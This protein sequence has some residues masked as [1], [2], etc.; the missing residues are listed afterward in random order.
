MS[1]DQRRE[2]ILDAVSRQV[3]DSDMT[4]TTKE[5]AQAAGVAEG[6]LFRVFDSKE[7][8]LIA[9]F[10]HRLEQM[11][12]DDVTN[13]S[14]ESLRELSSLQER[15]DSYIALVA[16]LMASWIH[17][18]AIF[19]R[20]LR[21]PEGQRGRSDLASHREEIKR[22]K[23]IYM[24]TLSHLGQCCRDLIAPYE[25]Q[26]SMPVDTV[27]AFVQSTVTSMA[28]AREFHDFGITA[29]DASAIIVNGALH[30]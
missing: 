20:F 12:R 1:S 7:D 27:V 10:S 21:G 28:M 3:V 8:L 18:I 25:D 15:L 24:E 16:D 23:S 14:L 4:M 17:M 26:L 30:R 11:A 2:A 9:A 6:T 19:R 22:I 29:D 5:L 13:S